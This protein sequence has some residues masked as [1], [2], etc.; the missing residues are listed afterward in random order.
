[1]KDIVLFLLIILGLLSFVAGVFLLIFLA[2][3]DNTDDSCYRYEGDI[4]LTAYEISSLANTSFMPLEFDVWVPLA[5]PDGSSAA[6]VHYY[7]RVVES[8]V[9][10]GNV[11]LTGDRITRMS[12]GFQVGAF[13]II[14]GIIVAVVSLLLLSGINVQLSGFC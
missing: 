9:N 10:I 4:V 13:M 5:T 12:L 6:Y 11:T 8:S 3:S 7:G 14:I 1:M 2:V